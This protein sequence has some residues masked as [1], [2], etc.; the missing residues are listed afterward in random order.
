M[1]IAARGAVN[2]AGGSVPADGAVVTAGFEFDVP[3]R[4]DSD[5]LE[6]SLSLIDARDSQYPDRG[7]QDMARCPAEL[8]AHLDSGATTLCTC[9]RVIRNDGSPLGSTDH[10]RDLEFDGTTFE[11]ATGSPD[12]DREHGRLG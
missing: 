4:F 8:Q 1:L 2:F 5:R 7:D 10:D 3:V 9:W 11:A 6:I 12:G